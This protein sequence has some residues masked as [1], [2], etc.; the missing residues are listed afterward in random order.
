VLSPGRMLQPVSLGEQPPREDS[1][2]VGASKFHSRKLLETQAGGPFVS[3][4]T[5]Q[6][7][8][9]GHT[10]PARMGCTQAEFGGPSMRT[11]RAAQAIWLIKHPSILLRNSRGRLLR[12]LTPVLTL[13]ATAYR[14]WYVPDCRIIVVVGSFGKTTS[15]HVITEAVGCGRTK[16][17]SN[18]LWGVA[19]EILTLRRRDRV[20]VV[21]AG[22]SI[23]GQMRT[24]A[25]ML[26]PNVVVVTSVGR[27]HEETL[28]GLEQIRA[29]KSVMLQAL[30]PNGLAVLNGDD[31]NVIWMRSK[32]AARVVY[33]GLSGRNDVQADEVALAYPPRLSLHVICPGAPGL[34]VATRLTSPIHVFSILAAI[35]TARH[36]GRSDSETLK[37]LELTGPVVQRMESVELQHGAWALIDDRKA[38]PDT[39][40]VALATLAEI[41]AARRWMVIGELGGPSKKNMDDDYRK[42]GQR[43]GQVCDHIVLTTSS[44]A[45]GEL[46]KSGALE[47]GLTEDRIVAVGGDFGAALE[48]LR[49]NLK[50]GDIVMIKGRHSERLTRIALALEGIDVQCWLPRC[51]HKGLACRTCSILTRG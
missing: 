35:A 32:T 4:E 30:K 24:F 6:F 17:R 51:T 7:P 29:E 34:S 27:E 3:P 11:L 20:V 26:R 14:R 22:I 15:R 16:G 50:A 10:T 48:H 23:P 41:P 21:E 1:Q 8:C 37:R 44:A 43:L 38:L 33:C 49:L 25:R 28:G 40:E 46:Y 42:C 2:R 36:L 9:L 39:V 13:L 12:S 5:L 45:Y 47:A 19:G 18:T 31:P